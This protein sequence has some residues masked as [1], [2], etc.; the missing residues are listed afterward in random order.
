MIYS[1]WQQEHFVT[2]SEQPCR[3]SGERVMLAHK[4]MAGIFACLLVSLT[5]PAHA[6]DADL[7]LHNG[8]IVTADK[9]FSIHQALA[10]GGE[11]ILRVGSNEEVLKTRG[12]KTQLI[13][14]GGKTVLPGLIDSHV[15]PTGACMTEFDHPIPEME[16]IADVLNYIKQRAKALAKGEWVEVHQVF[17]TRLREQRVSD[18]E[19]TRRDGPR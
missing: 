3:T 18:T 7:I 9:K 6:A 17:I 1:L 19:G 12:A 16:T 4:W 5:S 11:K 15:H 14:L 13:D 8:K 2:L 10:I